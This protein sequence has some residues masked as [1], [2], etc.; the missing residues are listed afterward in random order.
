MLKILLFLIPLVNIFAIS[1]EE[2]Y[3]RD[4]YSYFKRKLIRVKD[5]QIH[6]RLMHNKA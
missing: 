4:K 5:M 2:Y 6:Y 3:K 1:E